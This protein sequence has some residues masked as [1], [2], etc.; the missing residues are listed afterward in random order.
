MKIVD[1][2]KNLKK[3]EIGLWILS[4]LAIIMAFIIFKNKDYLS[5]LVSLIGVTSLIFLAKGDFIGQI[6]MIIF[7]LIYGYISINAK[8]YGEA[9]TYLGMT[10]PIAVLS[11]VVW[12]KNP[13][14]KHEVKV[15]EMTVNKYLVL[16]LLNMI[17]TVIFYF[18]LKALNTNNLIVSTISIST[19]FIAASLQAFRNRFYAIAYSLNDLV[20]IILWTLASVENNNYI[21]LI[22]CFVMFFINDIYGFINWT[23]MKNRQVNKN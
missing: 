15:S 19:S 12:I 16:F 6:L 20:L 9:I 23:I 10:L 14:S 3:H 1:S 7:S 21:S 2:I 22:V 4:L 13:Y 5:L 17:V 18:I 11:L 8:Y